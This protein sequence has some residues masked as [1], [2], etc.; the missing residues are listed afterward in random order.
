VNIHHIELFYYVAK[1]GGISEAIR[2]MPYGIQQPAMSAQIL[3]LEDDLGVK[4]FTRRPFSLTPPGQKLH[5]FIRPFFANLESVAAELHPEAAPHLRIGASEL[6]FRDH[7]PDLLKDLRPR[8]PRLKLSLKSGYQPQLEAWLEQ[9]EIDFAL[10]PLETN[11]PASLK[12]VSLLH[13]PLVLLVPRRSPIKDASELWARDKIEE[14]L[15]CLPPTETPSKN[16]QEGL[17]RLGVDWLPSV[18]A[19]SLEIISAYVRDGY[20]IG[21]SVAIPKRPFPRG[22]RTLPLEGFKPV[23]LGAL[24]YGEPNSL[25]KT[26]LEE[27]QRRAAKL[28]GAKG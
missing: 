22:L 16:F 6:V 4:L 10:I 13:L 19:S 2:H 24:W 25:E 23:E 17:A 18:E 26:V 8:F 20:G 28:A 27:I 21:L 3:R 14:P 11:P 5:K 12:M 9:R 1:H 15:I 7:L